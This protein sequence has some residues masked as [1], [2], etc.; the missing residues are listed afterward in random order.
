LVDEL[1]PIETEIPLGCLCF[2]GLLRY[3]FAIGLLVASYLMYLLP[4]HHTVSSA[5]I[6]LCGGRLD[7]TLQGGTPTLPEIKLIDNSNWVHSCNHKSRETYMQETYPSGNW[8]VL[9]HGTEEVTT[10][11]GE[12]RL[13]AVLKH[14]F[15]RGCPKGQV[16]K[17]G[18]CVNIPTILAGLL[19]Q[20]T[21]VNPPKCKRFD[22][23]LGAAACSAPQPDVCVDDWFS[24]AC[25]GTAPGNIHRN[26]C[27]QDSFTSC[28]EWQDVFRTPHPTL[29]CKAVFMCYDEP[30]DCIATWG[31]L[32]LQVS[33]ASAFEV[34][35][36]ATE[37]AVANGMATALNVSKKLIHILQVRGWPVNW[38]VDSS[39][40]DD[41][42]NDRRLEHSD[43]LPPELYDSAGR[44]VIDGTALVT[45]VIRKIPP[46]VLP[47]GIPSRGAALTASINKF[48]SVSASVVSASEFTTLPWKYI[49]YSEI[50]QE[51][52]NFLR[53]SYEEGGDTEFDDRL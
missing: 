41:D 5:S 27:G 44:V 20:E 51:D 26:A 24:Q 22:P 4:F 39:D 28:R 53:A 10:S 50:M 37:D 30:Y 45:Y 11:W 36:T 47:Q 6:A 46:T 42:G 34:S 40:N 21:S 48:H 12:K 43:Y 33:N 3:I 1:Q 35:Q 19:P 9:S 16:L 8:S 29:Y 2:L 14:A 23:S 18:K 25:D 32:E 31:K 7:F 15:N 38:V 49:L 13:D 17:L 52:L